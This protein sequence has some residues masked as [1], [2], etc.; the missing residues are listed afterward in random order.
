MSMVVS[1]NGIGAVPEAKWLACKGYR[2]DGSG[3][4]ATFIACCEYMLCPTDYEGNNPDCSKAPHVV[5]NSWGFGGDG[6]IYNDAIYAWNTAGMLSSFSAGNEAFLGCGSIRSPA[7]QPNILAVGCLD[8]DDRLSY[9][10]SLGPS[11]YR[12]IKPEISAPGHN[13]L[14][15]SAASDTAMRYFSGTSSACPSASGVLALLKTRD[16]NLVQARAAEILQ[17]TTNQTIPTGG[18]CGGISDIV[19]PNNHAGHGRIDAYSA[20]VELINT[21]SH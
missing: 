20:I 19:S 16:P 4:S 1:G 7:D 12:Q 5:S 2:D 13:I 10:S 3:S 11:P 14:S 8:S 6:S 17:K 9:Y 21:Q 15:A 18:K